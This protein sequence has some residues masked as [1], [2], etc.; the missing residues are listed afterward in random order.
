MSSET[1]ISTRQR[2]LNCSQHLFNSRGERNITTNHIAAE[3][4]MS[5]GN[6]YYHFRNKNDIIGALYGDHQKQLLNIVSLPQQGEFGFE[7]K[8]KLL[9]RLSASLW[10]FRF[11]YRDIEHILNTSQDISAAHKQTFNI[12]YKQ[13]IALHQMFIAKGLL[14]ASS[15][16]LRDLTY[17]VWI[18]LTNWISFLCTTSTITAADQS[19]QPYVQHAVYQILALEKPYMTALA[20]KDYDAL[21]QQYFV[22]LSQLYDI[23][24]CE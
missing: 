13:T 23:K 1:A 21:S 18:V 2:I 12:V 6:L 5:P 20:L 3:L 9:E 17:N 24:S 15:T 16:E 4:S 10:D 19:S 14:Q 8:A 7:E 11:F 22:D